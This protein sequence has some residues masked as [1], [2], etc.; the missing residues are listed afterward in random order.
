METKITVPKPCH[1]DWSKMSTNEKGRF[2]N[3]CS[4]TVVDFTVMNKQQIQDYFATTKTKT[5]GH[6]YNHQLDNKVPTNWFSKIKYAATIAFGLFLTLIGC[7]QKLTG[8]PAVN[9]DSIDKSTIISDSTK[10]N[11]TLGITLPANEKSALKGKVLAKDMV[12]GEVEIK[13]YDSTKTTN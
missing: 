3:A 4:T 5:C 7:K 12:D 6:F 13:H 1:E 10:L 8:E 11:H 2:C 9:N